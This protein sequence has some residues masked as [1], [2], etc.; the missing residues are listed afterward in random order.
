MFDEQNGNLVRKA[1]VTALFGAFAALLVARFIGHFFQQAE[2]LVDLTL[3]AIGCPLMAIFVIQA[4]QRQKNR[5]RKDVSDPTE[6][7]LERALTTL[8]IGLLLFTSMLSGPYLIL[9]PMI[10]I[11]LIIIYIVVKLRRR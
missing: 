5:A 7:K 4:T 3:I 11:V 10:S 8:A 6:A 9:V 1:V 2:A